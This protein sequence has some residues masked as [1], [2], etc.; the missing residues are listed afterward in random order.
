MDSVIKCYALGPIFCRRFSVTQIERAKFAH[1]SRARNIPRASSRKI[2]W[3]AIYIK[4]PRGPLSL[5]L[6]LGDLTLNVQMMRLSGVQQSIKSGARGG[7]FI[8]TPESSPTRRKS[9][10]DVELSWGARG[11][12]S[13]FCILATRQAVLFVP[14]ALCQRII[15]HSPT[16]Y[17]C[18]CDRLRNK[19]LRA[20]RIHART[21]YQRSH[22]QGS[23][24]AHTHMSLQTPSAS[25]SVCCATLATGTPIKK[26]SPPVYLSFAPAVVVAKSSKF[27]QD[28]CR[29][30]PLCIVVLTIFYWRIENQFYRSNLRMR[31]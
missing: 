8:F 26:R 21:K 29:K 3:A 5:S 17:V 20:R 12:C 24:R 25:A 18:V 22:T 27:S 19:A 11:R 7:R 1:F 2:S 23:W 4:I 6:S 16:F 9:I 13:C 31:F 10:D 14:D 28:A 30:K 15:G